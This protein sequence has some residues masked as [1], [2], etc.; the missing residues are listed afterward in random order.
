MQQFFTK[1]INMDSIPVAYLTLDKNG[2]VLTVNENWCTVTGYTLEEVEGVYFGDLLPD[3]QK[4]IFP[5]TYREFRTKQSTD[6]RTYKIRKKNGEYSDFI[7][8]A[9]AESDESGFIKAHF[10]VLDQGSLKTTERELTRSKYMYKLL[11][12]NIKEVVCVYNMTQGTH[13][14][15]SP[16]VMLLRGYTVEEAMNETL[17]ESLSDDSK[18]VFEK[19]VSEAEIDFLRKPDQDTP[20][21]LEVRQKCKD[22]TEINVEIQ[23]RFQLAANGDLEM[24]CVSRKLSSSKLEDTI[25]LMREREVERMAELTG[26]MFCLTDNEGRLI[27]SNKRLENTLDYKFIE[28]SSNSLSTII[29]PDD[30]LMFKTVLENTSD[31]FVDEI[32]CRIRHKGGEYRLFNWKITRFDEDK[33][34]VTARDITPPKAVA[35][36]AIFRQ[37]LASKNKPLIQI[38]EKRGTR[39]ESY[40]AEISEGRSYTAAVADFAASLIRNLNILEKQDIE[41]Q[42][43]IIYKVARTASI[44]S[45][46]YAFINRYAEGNHT[47]SPL[48]ISLE[49]ETKSA[50]EDLAGMY[51]QKEMKISVKGGE[52][53]V[54]IYADPSATKALIRSMISYMIR[55]SDGRGEIAIKC[56]RE[57]NTALFTINHRDIKSPSD[58]SSIISIEKCKEVASSMGGSISADYNSSNGTTIKIKLPAVM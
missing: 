48:L 25:R 22:G 54:K 18:P 33:V 20:F 26:D 34:Y 44:Q 35:N 36:K 27:K 37:V 1:Q 6:Y 57:D 2:V 58:K 16:S 41:S 42:L 28:L 9:G 13:L 8:Y 49:S 50:L 39:Q 51:E 56:I 53:D 46:D 21:F 45:E 24:I 55:L 31:D 52:A 43:R 7:I 4:N 17:L 12:D 3:N 10:L 19:A 23:A 38:G 15:V 29:Y 32:D 14:Y 11:A 40:V 47:P 30:E 5:K